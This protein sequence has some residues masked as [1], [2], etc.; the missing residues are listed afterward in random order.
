MSLTQQL[1]A[2]FRLALYYSVIMVLLTRRPMHLTVLLTTS[3]LTALVFEL[4]GRKE[5]FFVGAKPKCA[6]PS[7]DN[8]FMNLLIGTNRDAA[9]CDPLSAGV[10]ARIALADRT[11]PTDGPFEHGR[12]DRAFYTMP[13]TE[14]PNRRDELAQWLYS[15][16]KDRTTLAK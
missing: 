12:T 8:P 9:A 6:L 7:K 14:V 4:S 11:P 16:Q 10:K 13:N 5:A 2:L 3:A 1:N 15:G